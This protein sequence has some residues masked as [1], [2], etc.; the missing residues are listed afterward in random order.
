M[1]EDQTQNLFGVF[2]QQTQTYSCEGEES[3][4]VGK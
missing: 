4:V 1:Q 2:D 3:R